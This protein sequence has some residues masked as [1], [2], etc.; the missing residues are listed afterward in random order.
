L[1]STTSST[2]PWVTSSTVR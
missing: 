1:A 2:L